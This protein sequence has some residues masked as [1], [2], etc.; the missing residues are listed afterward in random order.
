MIGCD[1]RN[2][3]YSV[4]YSSGS[5]ILRQA[6]IVGRIIVLFAGGAAALSQETP[7]DGLCRGLTNLLQLEQARWR[8]QCV[9]YPVRVEAS[10]LWADQAQGRLFLQDDSGAIAL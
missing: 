7:N 5:T 4:T 8:D 1:D 9:S 6:R 10:V 2:M 3:K